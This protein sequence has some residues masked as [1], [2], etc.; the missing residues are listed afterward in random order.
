MINQLYRLLFF[1][2]H[3]KRIFFGLGF[4][5]MLCVLSSCFVSRPAYP[6]TWPSITNEVAFLSN[7]GKYNIKLLSVLG[8]NDY[9]D[10]QFAECSTSFLVTEDNQLQFSIH[11]KDS[12]PKDQSFNFILEVPKIRI[13]VA[14]KKAGLMLNY[15]D[16]QI[17]GDPLVGPRKYYFLFSL[18]NDGSLIVKRGE[19]FYGMA[20]LLIPVAVNEYEWYR[21]T[22]DQ[23]VEVVSGKK[24]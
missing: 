13:K 20:M 2:K 4:G 23:K 12:I 1:V 16:L 17:A 15:H 21:F 18:A 3:Q 7:S 5:M 8:N 22:Q 10:S 9:M 11:C 6:K 19:W 14:R 24:K